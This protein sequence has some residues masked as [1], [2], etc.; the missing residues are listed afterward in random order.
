M[1]AL[2]FLFL[3]LVGCTNNGP[4]GTGNTGT[5]TG[6]TGTGTGTGV[7]YT[8]TTGTS[9]GAPFQHG[10][11]DLI[12]DRNWPGLRVRIDYVEGHGPDPDALDEMR[13]ELDALV[14]SGHIVKPAGIELVLD[15]A[16]PAG[17]PGAV[18][19]FEQLNYTLGVNAG[20]NEE[21]DFVIIHALW[22]D[23]SYETDGD[24][25]L[26]LGFAYGSNRLVMLADNIE[27]GCDTF[28]NGPL[29]LG[30]GQ[31]VC[32]VTEATVGMHELGHL[33]GL[34]NNGLDM[35]VDHQDE[36]HGRHD[37]NEDCLMYWAVEGST[38]FEAVAAGSGL[39][40]PEVKQFDAECLAD[41]MAAQTN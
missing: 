32:E 36:E 16:L 28:L 17:D 23:G 6:A 33:F 41:M 20:P 11:V 8:G 4:G 34:V 3:A 38:A 9:T 7:G 25:G 39:G 5:A 12:T 30:M 24:G 40:G 22:T 31:R 26:T 14:A 27:R 2:P 21:G 19:T 13:T 15:D 37:D 1:R 10:P 35:Q 29:G 18:Y